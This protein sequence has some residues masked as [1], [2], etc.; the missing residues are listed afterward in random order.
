MEKHLG[1][2]LR[3]TQNRTLSVCMLSCFR[4]RL[5]ATPWTVT[6]LAPVSMGFPRQECWSGLPFPSHAGSPAG[7]VTLTL[8]LGGS[9]PGWI[10]PIQGSNLGL[11]HCGQ[12]LYCL[13]HQGSPALL[14]HLSFSLLLSLFCLAAAH[15]QY[16]PRE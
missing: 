2:S 14:T 15:D 1:A 8:L 10:F 4:V 16:H 3:E 13:G 6:C 12:I 5:L 7:T 11:P 9:S